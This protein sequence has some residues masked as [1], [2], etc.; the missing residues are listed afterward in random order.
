MSLCI[1]HK[2]STPSEFV[3]GFALQN[4]V[5]LVF[6]VVEESPMEDE[7]SAADKPFVSLRLFA[8][9]SDSAT[10][11]G[12]LPVTRNR[13]DSGD[14]PHLSMLLVKR[15][16]LG[17]INIGETIAVGQHEVVALN[18]GLNPLDPCPRARFGAGATNVADHGS[19]AVSVRNSRSSG[20]S[21]RRVKSLFLTR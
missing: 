15:P 3:E 21:S 20:E 8:K 11:Y 1:A 5:V 7:E 9:D 12:Q 10:I 6:Q 18:A 13:P 14:R 2:F 19:R 16:E 4:A 17:G